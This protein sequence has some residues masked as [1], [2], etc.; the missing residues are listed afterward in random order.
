MDKPSSGCVPEAKDSKRCCSCVTL[1][2]IVFD[3][4]VALLQRNSSEQQT[5]C[6]QKYSRHPTLRL[7][8]SKH[9]PCPHEPWPKLLKGGLS[10][11]GSKYYARP[12]LRGLFFC[13]YEYV[14]VH[15]HTY[16][17]TYTY[18]IYIYIYTY[19][20]I[21]AHTQTHT[22]IYIYVYVSISLHI[23]RIHAHTESINSS[24]CG[25]QYGSSDHGSHGIEAGP[26]ASWPCWQT[27][28]ASSPASMGR[29]L[30]LFVTPRKVLGSL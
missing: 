24:I 8:R 20:Y 26:T 16:I 21:H 25:H 19:T 14:Y 28:S 17:H 18:Y 4:L 5:V 13:V 1:P 22:Y 27:S 6:S 23:S 11:D 29:W 10:R 2:P 12:E 15:I 3:T 30:F 9:V 7:P